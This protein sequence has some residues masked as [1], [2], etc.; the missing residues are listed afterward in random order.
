MKRI[1]LHPLATWENYLDGVYDRTAFYMYNSM[2][3][4]A[5]YLLAERK[6]FKQHFKG[7]KEE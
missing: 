5:D 1:E 7:G 6:Y 3:L 2:M 4:Y